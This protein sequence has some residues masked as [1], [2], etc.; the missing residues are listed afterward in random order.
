MLVRYL[1]LVRP[2]QI[3]L[4][5]SDL[6]FLTLDDDELRQVQYIVS[7]AE[8]FATA[9]RIISRTKGPTIYLVFGLYN[10]VFKSLEKAKNKLRVKR[11][12]WKRDL[13]KALE[14]AW[15]KLAKY[16]AGTMTSLGHLYGHAV[17]L[18][19]YLKDRF[20]KSEA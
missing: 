13:V 15:Q 9:T 6:S 14:N 7:L 2:V 20:F 11:V 10:K 18:N 1:R 3:Y 19:P 16:Y 8:P 12:A 4:D 5:S 17:L